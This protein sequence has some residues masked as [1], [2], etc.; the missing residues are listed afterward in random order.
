[1]S[2]DTLCVIWF[3]LLGAL[4]AGYAMLDGF[5]LGVGIMHPFLF[6]TD[7]ERERILGTIGPVWD[8]NEVWL[9]TFGGAMFAMFPL[10]YASI[11]SGFYSSVMLLILMLIVRALSLQF[12]SNMTSSV[13][14]HLWDWMFCASSFTTAFLFGLSIGNAVQGLS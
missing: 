6:Q 9:V 5:D 1:M 3:I 11:F 13:G 10:A 2:Y 7:S 14:R 4:L 12:R 8:G